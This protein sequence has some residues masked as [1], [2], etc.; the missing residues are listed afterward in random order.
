MIST[1]FNI[2]GGVAL[3]L[4]GIRLLSEALQFIA[5]D[6]MRKLIGTL[7]KTPLRGIFVGIIV[8]VLIQSSTGTTVMTV[9]FVN[10]GLLNLNQAIGIIM[11]A[12]IGTTVTAQIIAFKI[13]AFALPLV[14]AGMIMSIFA[15]NKKQLSYLA[16]GVIGL[17]LLFLGMQTMSSKEVVG[18]ISQHT[19]FILTLSRNP[20]TG[21]LAG[22]VLTILI[23]SS[24]ATIG[25]VI[26]IAAN[27]NGLIGL[28]AAIPII[29]GDNIGTTL[30]AIVVAMGATRP[31]KQAAA[32]HV[33]FNLIGTV[34]FLL[35]FPLYREIV[36]LSSPDIGRQI[37]NAHSIFN[38]LNTVLFFPFVPLLAK[39]IS[40]I[41]PLRPEDRPEDVMYLDLNLISISSAS[42]AEAVKDEILHMGQIIQNMFV[43]IRE[44]FWDFDSS[45]I[46]ERKKKFDHYEESVNKITESISAYASEIWQRGVSDEISTVLGSY[47]NASID[48]ERIGDRCENL[49][50]RCD[51]M[52]NYLSDE[53]IGELKDMYD[54]TELAVKTSLKSLEDEN[55]VQAWQVIRD[56]EK[57]I[58]SQE[59]R[60]RKAHIDRLN[61]GE[62]DPE[63]GVNFIT[64][65]SN[66]ERIG[67]H[68]NNIAGYT[69]DIIQLGIR[70]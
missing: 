3:F 45:K 13:E 64:L 14:A 47:V 70:K 46:D 68:S 7:T 4:Y 18:I 33:L 9:S 55:A 51:V 21:V 49:L 65:L 67:D 63:K 12:N 56:I 5:G 30:T 69:L 37:A 8:T 27:S 66:L 19:D 39:L 32:A 10:S 57:K 11:G 62:C 60:Y 36:I 16:S 41:I 20:L 6:K 29:L 17:G 54:T 58:D 44:A 28:D 34:I 26:A 31:A 42:A 22:M 40:K 15:K 2:A 23:Q 52:N 1:F 35:A 43:L 53:A 25:L 59:R 38:V 24:A 61:R 50:E 48:L